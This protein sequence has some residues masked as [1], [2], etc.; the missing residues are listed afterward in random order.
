MSL[1]TL[2]LTMD[3]RSTVLMSVSRAES[4]VCSAALRSAVRLVA[5][6]SA[7]VAVARHRCGRDLGPDRNGCVGKGG[8]LHAEGL[9]VQALHREMDGKDQLAVKESERRTGREFAVV[10]EGQG[11]LK[12]SLRRPLGR[13]RIGDG[14]EDHD[15]VGRRAILDG[16][17]NPV[18]FKCTPAALVG[19]KRETGHFREI[20]DEGFECIHCSSPSRFVLPVPKSF[21]GKFGIDIPHCRPKHLRLVQ[22]D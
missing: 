13:L 7:I 14:G 5:A 19:L 21:H 15:I 22:R 16:D 11:F 17:E 12:H 2:P 20:R 1:I 3:L 10:G 4:F 6:L 8:K 18:R 9:R